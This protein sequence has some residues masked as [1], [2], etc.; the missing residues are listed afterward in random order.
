VI[1][2]VLSSS[3]V[4]IDACALQTLRQN[5]TQQ[6]V[7][8]T[9]TAIPFPTVPHVTPERVHRLFEMERA[10]GVGPALR[11]KALIRSAAFGLQERVTI[12]GLL[13]GGFADLLSRLEV[14]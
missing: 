5:G 10:N 2:G 12:S 6:N 13:F 4:T 8:E 7:V 11:E 14:E 1:A 3:Y 9:E